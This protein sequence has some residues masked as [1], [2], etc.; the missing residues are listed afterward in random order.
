[1]ANK[2]YEETDIQAIADAIRAKG[3]SGTMLVSEMADAIAAIPTGG[4]GGWQR[5][6]DW[7]QYTDELIE[8]QEVIFLTMDNRRTPDNI[9]PYV[10]FRIVTSTGKYRVERGQIVDGAFVGITVADVNSSA[11]FGENI[12]EGADYAVYKITALTGHITSMNLYSAVT[13]ANGTNKSETRQPMLERFGRVPFLV[14]FSNTDSNNFAPRYLVSDTLRDMSSLNSNR[15]SWYR[16]CS[17]LKRVDFSGI[18]NARL[19]YLNNVFDGCSSLEEIVG[20]SDLVTSSARDLHSMFSNCVSLKALDLHNWDMSNVTSVDSM[21]SGCRA[22]EEIN[23]TGWNVAN[24]VNTNYMFANCVSLESVDMSTWT[25][26]IKITAYQ[27]PFQHCS[28]LKYLNLKGF[29]LMQE[30]S[31]SSAYVLSPPSLLNTLNTE[32][33]SLM[34]ATSIPSSTFSDMGVINWIHPPE[35][36]VSFSIRGMSSLSDLSLVNIANEML[37]TE[38]TSATVTLHANPKARLTAILGT[39]A[40]GIFTADESGTV[41]LEN[42]ITQTKGWTIA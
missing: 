15:S 3:H 4:G 12:P 40:D 19:S 34:Q 21:F 13:W 8:N 29:H 30:G 36:K 1:M 17:A 14:S 5:P 18:S 22:I 42:F 24:V 23:M 38:A 28:S 25:P 33:N 27:Q 35:A 32:D 11:D 31:T 39:V 41:T 2:L 6:S 7:P 9:E 16:N 26:P 10:T 20:L 37:S